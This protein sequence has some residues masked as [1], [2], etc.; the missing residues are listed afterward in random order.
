MTRRVTRRSAASRTACVFCGAV[1]GGTC[2]ATAPRQQPLPPAIDT[3]IA[4]ARE[5][6]TLLVDHHG[7]APRASCRVAGRRYGVSADD[8]YLE[9]NVA[10]VWLRGPLARPATRP[11]RTREIDAETEPREHGEKETAA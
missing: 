5:W 1:C 11:T 8:L 3:A 2:T 9:H 10:R 7:L 6:A 4:L